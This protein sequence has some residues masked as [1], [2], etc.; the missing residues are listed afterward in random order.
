[1]RFEY[2]DGRMPLP[3]TQGDMTYYL[4]YDPVGSLRLVADESG[5][6]IKTITYDSFGNVLMIPIRSLTSP[7]GLAAAYTT[8]IQVLYDSVTATMIPI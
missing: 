5:N 6:V 4:S 3:M 1:M 2:A 7:L 8:K